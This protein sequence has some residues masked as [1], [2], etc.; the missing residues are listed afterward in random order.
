MGFKRS[1]Y[2]LSLFT[3]TLSCFILPAIA[4]A[5]AVNIAEGDMNLT[6]TIIQM[7]GVVSGAIAIHWFL[8]QL[9]RRLLAIVQRNTD[10]R[11]GES[12][13]QAPLE[14]FLKLLVG[15][16]R[17]VLWSSVAL[18]ITN[19]FPATRRWS[20]QII[21]TLISGFTAPILT[22]GNRAYSV[23]DFFILAALLFGI[24]IL[25]GML[26]N[27]LRYRVLRLAGINRGLQE[28]IATLTRYGLITIATI[29]L[30][31][32]WGLDLSSLTILASTLGVGIGF[33][34]Q[35]IAKNFGS[36]LVLVFERPIQVGDFVE[37]AEFKG[38]VERI[39][40]RSTEIRTLDHVSIIVP[41]S[42]FLENE[43]INWSHR[44]PVSRLHIPVGVAYHAD[45]QIV[46]EALLEAAQNHSDIVDSPAPQVLFQG[47]GD[48][49]L[50]FE[51]L[52]WTAVP[53]RQFLLKSDL[54]FRIFEAFRRRQIE[55]PF[56]QQDLHLRSV[57][58]SPELES[59]WNQISAQFSNG[60]APPATSTESDLTE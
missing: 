51:L 41:N 1:I 49:A 48:S 17:I 34:L 25:A 26:T 10:I 36:G 32:V 57:Q 55:I 54:N 38:T 56:P 28:V 50:N 6:L 35:D 5:N 27:L 19:L 53:N 44:N 21:T 11:V 4:Q 45:P 47:F 15:V 7:I 20:N 42:R 23:I 13:V 30:L 12:E 8:G 9:K 43:V 16:A 18:F 58:V 52:V 39:G 31:Q 2:L 59:T 60:F 37:I 29:I 22:L 3:L 46:Q 14:L 33:G 40:A 24:T